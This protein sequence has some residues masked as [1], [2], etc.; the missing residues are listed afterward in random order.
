MKFKII[1]SSITVMAFLSACN[2]ENQ[3]EGLVS[4]WHLIEQLMD[5]GD[6]SGTFQ[7]VTSDKTI[8]FFEDGTVSSANGSICI[9]EV[10]SGASSSLGTYS[11]TTMI[12]DVDNCTGG[13][14]P[15]SY[16]MD[17]NYLIL[18]YACIEPCREKYEQVE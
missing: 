9:G 14:V 16:E 11:E 15:L 17:G 18:N 8:S 2:T 13:H 4:K 1:I 7:P 12:I 5:P 10:W 6:G 3:N